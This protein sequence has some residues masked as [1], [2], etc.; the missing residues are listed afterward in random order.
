[1]K[2]LGVISGEGRK[3]LSP[4]FQQAAIDALG[5]DLVY[6]AWPTP[7]EGL[8]TRVTTLRAPSA[9]GANVTIPHKE[10]IIPLLD[11]LDASASRVGAVNT[12]RNQDGTLSAHNTDVEG[13][14]RGLRVDGGM[15]PRG[16]HALIAGAGGAARAVAIALIDAGAASVTIINRTYS[17]ASRLVQSLLETTEGAELT[18][19]P[20]MYPSW[21][22][23]APRCTLLVNCTPAGSVSESDAGSAIPF[24]IL[25]PGMLV[26]DLV[27]LPSE[28]PL[29]AAARSRGARVL[30]GLPMLIYQGAASLELWTG[31]QAPVEVMFAAAREALDAA[32]TGAN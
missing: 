14:L 23:A 30:G 9:L 3:S 1:M 29:M 10:A 16:Q 25:R 22:S 17:R 20:D 4:I 6:E 32:A 18:A 15:D 8:N 5:L 12:V 21:V 31:Q 24:D 13:F 7:P 26:H 11:E 19:L 28:T 2:H 27:Y